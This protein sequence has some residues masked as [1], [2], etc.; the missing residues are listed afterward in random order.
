MSFEITPEV[1]RRIDDNITYI[2]SSTWSRREK[3]MHWRRVMKPR[4]Q[5]TRREYVQWLLETAQIHDRNGGGRYGF[6]DLVEFATLFEVDEFGEGLVLSRNDIRDGLA[7]DRAGKWAKH[8]ASA[9][10]YWP[11]KMMHAALKAGKT[12]TMAYDGKTLF[13]TDHPV[14]P[15]GSTATYRN[16][17]TG[18][19][20]SPTN[21]AELRAYI[22]TIKAPDGDPRMLRPTIVMS[23]ADLELT[24]AHALGAESYTDPTNGDQPGG[25]AVTNMIKQTFGMEPPISADEIDEPGVW[26]LFCELVED[27]ELAGLI[28]SE[29]DPYELTTL[30]AYDDAELLRAKEF[31]WD[32]NGRN[33]VNTGHPFLVH[34]CEP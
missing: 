26:Y 8:I 31:M 28:Y 12:S 10:V 24:V 7:F 25:T 2:F 13:A 6:D 23:G 21:L 16:L 11:Q 15:Y 29:R 4:Q 5:T 14:N 18:M 3:Q 34:R 27:D 1:L 9:G 20:F 19:P 33:R 17:H 30:T 22:R 32:L